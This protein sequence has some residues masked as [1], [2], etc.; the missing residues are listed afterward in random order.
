MR[1]EGRGFTAGHVRGLRQAM[2]KESEGFT[3]LRQIFPNNEAKMKEGISVG[4]QTTIR[5]L[6]L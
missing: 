1:L 2:E 4:P 3:Y 5:R 6:R